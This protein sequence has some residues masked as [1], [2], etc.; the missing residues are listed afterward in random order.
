MA[1]KS[2]HIPISEYYSILQLEYISF[3]LREAIYQKKYSEKYKPY[4]E[5]KKEKIES[6]AL[7]NCL[8][9]IFNSET[10]REKYLGKFFNEFGLPNFTYK[11]EDSKEKMGKWDKYYYFSPGTSVKFKVEDS[12]DIQIGTIVSNLIEEES[13]VVKTIEKEEFTLAYSKVARMLVESLFNF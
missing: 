8:P 9:S 6:I 2:R 12:K 4:C 10:S 7:Q 11:N 13:V 5:G 3:R 1:N